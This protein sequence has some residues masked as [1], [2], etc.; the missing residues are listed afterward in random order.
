MDVRP[1]EIIKEGARSI[2]GKRNMLAMVADG[3][4]EDTMSTG[5]RGKIGEDLH[6]LEVAGVLNH[7]C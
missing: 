5:K 6:M 4:A 2:L 3:E 7:P 1:M